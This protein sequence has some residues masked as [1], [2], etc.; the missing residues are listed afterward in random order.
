MNSRESNPYSY[1]KTLSKGDPEYW[2]WS[3]DEIGR[4]DVAA[5]IDHVLN[6]TGAS[7]VTLLS[8]SQGVTI[9]LVLLSTRPEYNDK[10][11]IVVAYGPVANVGSMG[12]PMPLLLKVLQLLTLLMD[13]G[14]KGRYVNVH[15]AVT[16][17]CQIL[18]GLLCTSFIELT[19]LSSPSQFNQTRMPMYGAHYPIGTT[20]QNLH[21]YYQIYRANDFIMYD[22][23]VKENRRRYSQ[24]TPPAYPMERIR[25][26][27]ALFSSEGDRMADPRDVDYLVSRLGDNVVLHH[28]VPQPTMRHLDFAVGF[29]ATEF[30]HKVAIDVIHKYADSGS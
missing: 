5:G 27:F 19:F 22:H 14:Q 20:V 30:L 17:G 23:G 9:A 2:Q 18:G 28:V 26:L 11:D 3:F 12:S 15:P 21:H 29:N 4:H 10:V 7:K 8:L 1:H 13:P 24:A 6:A 25:T 16:V